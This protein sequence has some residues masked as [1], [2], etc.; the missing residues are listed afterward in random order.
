MTILKGFVHVLWL[1]CASVFS[2][3]VCRMTASAVLLSMQ[4]LVRWPNG[5]VYNERRK[6]TPIEK[7]G[8]INRTS[9]TGKGGGLWQRGGLQ[10]GADG[11]KRGSLEEGYTD[12]D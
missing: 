9:Q 7:A 1:W 10:E 5:H 12:R 8:M 4:L 2:T 11:R 3:P 6:A